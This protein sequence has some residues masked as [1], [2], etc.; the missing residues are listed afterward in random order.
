MQ[1]GVSIIFVSF[2]LS[3]LSCT[4]VVLH[5]P[6]IPRARIEPLLTFQ[7]HL[8]PHELLV[9]GNVRV[10]IE[11]V[12]KKHSPPPPPHP[13]FSI[14]RREMNGNKIFS[15]HHPCFGLVQATPFCL[16]KVVCERMTSPS[17]LPSVNP[18]PL[19]HPPAHPTHPLSFSPSAYTCLFECRWHKKTFIATQYICFS[20]LSVAPSR[21]HLWHARSP[22]LIILPLT[23]SFCMI[24]IHFVCCFSPTHMS[25]ANPK[26]AST[27]CL[28]VL[29]LR[30]EQRPPARRCL[31]PLP[32][33]CARVCTLSVL[34]RF[35]CPVCCPCSSRDRGVCMFN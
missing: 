28:S 4:G 27:T 14:Q 7:P 18:S 32:R 8:V 16:K 15:C 5:L 12:W 23:P 22:G 21:R 13:P 33:L 9:V 11:F 20:I 25:Q 2:L 31:Q 24:S 3:V 6:P 19:P 17:P 10:V 34:A 26:L 1:W 30:L 29:C 35:V